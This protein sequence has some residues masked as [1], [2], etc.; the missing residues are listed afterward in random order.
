MEYGNENDIK[1]IFHKID[2][3]PLIVLRIESLGRSS[4][5]DWK[6]S[7]LDG[8][9]VKVFLFFVDFNLQFRRLRDID[10]VLTSN[11]D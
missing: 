1:V 9:D 4:N 2:I 6:N 10:E 3:I 7:K 5:N 8:Y 11:E